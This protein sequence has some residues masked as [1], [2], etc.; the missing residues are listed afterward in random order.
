LLVAGSPASD[1]AL[2]YPVRPV[3]LLAII[4]KCIVA[5]KNA[6]ADF[7]FITG[8][9]FRGAAQTESIDVTAGDGSYTSTKYWSEVTTLDCSDNAA[10]G[11]TVWADGDL[12]VT[13]DIWGVICDFGNGQ[14]Y[15]VDA[16]FMI[17]SGGTSTYFTSLSDQV[18]FGDAVW[19]E[20]TALA[21]LTMGALTD[22]LP[23]NGSVWS[24]KGPLATWKDIGHPGS[25]IYLYGSLIQYKW[26]G[27]NIK[28]RG[29]VTTRNSLILS[30][31]DPNSGDEYKG[32]IAFG[33]SETGTLDIDDLFVSS[34][35][36]NYFQAGTVTQVKRLKLHDTNTRAIDFSATSVIIEAAEITSAGGSDIAVHNATGEVVNAVN[37][38][39]S[40]EI[41]NASGSLK[42]SFYCNIVVVDKDG[43]GIVGATILCEGSDSG[44][45]SEEYD[46]QVF[47]EDTGVS[48]VLA[49]Q[50]INQKKW[51]T[52]NETLTNY[53]Y[54]KFTI[55]E[56]GYETLVLGKITVDGPID[57]HLELQSQKQPPA[58]WQEGMM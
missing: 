37:P 56:P 32:Q 40:P 14:Q 44:T 12:S 4:V 49:Q 36:T 27:I 33:Y 3:E 55:S 30:I 28:T 8:K 35:R 20:V 18:V 10:G 9:D 13:Q 46:T 58:P 23:S 7:I 45:A 31:P 47:S 53:N 16:I 48:G 41:Y 6:E 42:E 54:F 2:D 25:E 24:V 34:F 1:L 17:G 11:G 26:H 38:I 57:W 19:W 22:G 5:N 29:I 50:K 39:T 43:T 52:T 15:Q 21:T 51:L